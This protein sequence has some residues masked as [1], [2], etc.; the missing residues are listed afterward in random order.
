L[1]T[2]NGRLS[3]AS[4]LTEIDDVI[5]KMKFK[6]AMADANIVKSVKEQVRH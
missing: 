3:A 5:E 2:F 1:C 6:I 4:S